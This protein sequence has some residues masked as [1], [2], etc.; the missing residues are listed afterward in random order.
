MPAA[1]LGVIV[2]TVYALPQSLLLYIEV[3]RIKREAGARSLGPGGTRGKCE[4]S[5]WEHHGVIVNILIAY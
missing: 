2:A 3:H 4:I 1:A 5:V